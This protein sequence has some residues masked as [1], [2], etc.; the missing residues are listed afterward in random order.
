[1]RFMFST[2]WMICRRALRLLL[3]GDVHLGRDLVH[4]LDGHPDLPAPRRLLAGRVGGLGHDLVDVL[5]GLADLLAALG[6]ARARRRSRSRWPCSCRRPSA[7]PPSEAADCLAVAG[8]IWPM[9]SEERVTRLDDAAEREAGRVGELDALL[10]LGGARLGRLHGG[11]R[12]LLDLTDH[13]ADLLRR[14]H[15]ALGELAHLVGHHREP[16]PGLAGARGLD[17][18]VQ[19]EEVG[20]V[21]DLLDDLQ[22]LADLLATACRGR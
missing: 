6:L 1:M 17:G 2:E 19:G 4:V 15:R 7:G 5:H 16:A 13:L 8:A 22:D 10:G 14:L 9:S 21:G 3:G 18:G 20:L 11:R 12:L